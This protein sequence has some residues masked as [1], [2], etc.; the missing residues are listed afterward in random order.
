MKIRPVGAKLFHA[1]GETNMAK[2]TVAFHNFA[3]APNNGCRCS[4]KVAYHIRIFKRYLTCWLLSN[5]NNTSTQTTYWSDL[6]FGFHLMAHRGINKPAFLCLLAEV[7]DY[8]CLMHFSRQQP[9][10]LE[11]KI[12]IPPTSRRPRPG[13]L[14]VR[15]HDIINKL[16]ILYISNTC[17]SYNVNIRAQG[18]SCVPW[19]ICFSY[20]RTRL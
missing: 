3:S 11:C 20:S 7:L 16:S 18:R 14:D 10:Y 4:F 1:D 17:S 5:P 19:M 2:L 13:I 6:Q 8:A 9:Y 15:W 12:N